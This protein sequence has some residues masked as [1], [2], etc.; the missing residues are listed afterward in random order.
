MLGD[1]IRAREGTALF[2]TVE[3]IRR[4]AKDARQRRDPSAPLLEK[5]LRDLPLD[6]AVPVA[7]AF[8]HFL[9]LANI[10]EQHHRVRRRRDY[11]REGSQGQRGS[12]E[13]ILPRILESG[14]TSDELYRAASELQIALVVTAHPTAITRRTLAAAHVRI[15]RALGRRDRADL[16]ALEREESDAD[17]RREILTMWGTEDVRRQRPTP[18]DEVRSGLFVFEQTL[19]DAV[20]RCLRAMDRVLLALTGR[21]LPLTAAPLVFGSWI[22]GD[23]DGNPAITH[24]VTREACAAA[25]A[26]AAALYAREIESL[27]V[28]LP[29]TPAT[30]E[31]RDA[32]SG[33]PE[34]YRAVLRQLA[35][36]LRDAGTPMTAADLRGPLDLCHRSLSA[37]GQQLVADGRLTDVLR[38]VA[39]FGTTLVR[40]DIRQHADRHAAALDAIARRLGRGSYLAMPEDARQAFLRDALASR[41]AVPSGLDA[42]GD[43]A[44]VLA[45]FR[46]IAEIPTESLG[47]YVV[48]MT[49]APSDILAVEY[50][51]QAHGSSLRVVPLFEEVATLERAGEIVRALL[52]P[53]LKVRPT[54]DVAFA[55]TARSAWDV[56]RTF[57]SGDGVEIMLGYSDSAKDGG[58]L[59]ANWLLYKAQ[60]SVVAAGREAGTAVTLFHGRGGSIGRG[61]G[62]I[63]LAMQSQPPGTINGRLRVTVQGEMIEEQFGLPEIAVRTLE[64]YATSVLRASLAEPRPLPAEWRTAMDRLAADAHAVYRGTVYDDPRFLEYF[65]AAT[66]EREIALAPIGSRPAR[67]G[68]DG[69]VE[70]LRAIPWVFAWTQTRLLLPSWLGTGEALEAAAARGERDLVQRMAREWPFFG[71]TLRLIEMALAEAEPPIAEAYDRALVPDALRDIGAALRARLALAQRTA[72]DALGA[73]T[74]L[75]DNPVLRRSIDVRNPYVDPI[76]LLQIALL[77]HLRGDTVVTDELW[78]AFLVTVNGIA[79]GMRN[80]G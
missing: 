48:S 71:A 47:A 66:P 65:R 57:R 60:E 27:F 44:E 74:L 38:R 24:A 69:G 77:S 73:R 15:A 37:T 32:A 64:V 13:H 17:L 79:A 80:V 54:L 2:D 55:P 72:L 3:R 7:R 61:G 52:S 1:T 39:A 50:L 19:W 56:G 46:T 20:P 63:H 53:D 23:R 4:M 62:P 25:R 36:R 5:P 18:L 75:E 42:G 10:A 67:R 59:A 43:V 76:N 31:L 22:G 35:A 21:R 41:L 68:G 29:V 8:S 34:P 58:R 14:V 16:S 49:R 33:A 30:P 11:Q 26:T 12:F 9:A 51:Q 78:Q 45:T 28:E 6:Q 70:S 40:L